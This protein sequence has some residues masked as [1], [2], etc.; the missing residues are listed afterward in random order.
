M[1]LFSR[2]GRRQPT[3][4][5][6]GE[7]PGANPNVAVLSS[8]R[9]TLAGG[10]LAADRGFLTYGL[11]G[12][13]TVT[14]ASP[15]PGDNRPRPSLA[16]SLTG[17]G[18]VR[19]S[20]GDADASPSNPPFPSVD[21][22]GAA[23]L[24]G[25]LSGGAWASES[26]PIERGPG[27]LVNLRYLPFDPKVTD[28]RTFSKPIPEFQDYRPGRAI[29][30]YYIDPRRRWGV[31]P[32]F[33][34]SHGSIRRTPVTTAPNSQLPQGMANPTVYRPDPKPWDAGVLRGNPS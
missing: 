20:M 26:G 16:V 19:G 32:M 15:Y 21:P 8:G 33:N 30:S 14:S 34:G 13:Q 4:A 2:L 9:G 5:T 29:I 11:G 18:V 3:G 31:E 6:P 24:R 12:P 25:R 23:S 27:E 22:A 17:R 28:P 10:V 7:T 1:G